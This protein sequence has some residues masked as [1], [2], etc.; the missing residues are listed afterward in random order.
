MFNAT[1]LDAWLAHI[2]ALHAKQID[3]GL[4]RMSLM[5]E[6]MAIAFPNQTVI[7]VGGTNGKGSTCSM[8]ESIYRAAGYRT[9]MHTSPHLIRM[10]ERC[11]VDGREVSDETLIAAF[12][13]VEAARGDMTL[14][15][16]EY[17]ALAILRI[18]VEERVDVVILEVGLGGRLD[19]I[20]TVDSNAAVV[21][22][23]GIDHVAFLGDTRE[24]IGFEKAHIFRGGCPAVCSEPDVP[25]TVL[26]KIDELGAKGL[27]ANRDFKVTVNADTTFDFEMGDLSW[28]RIP[29]PALKGVNQY[30]NVGG[31][32]AIVSSLQ[33]RLPV[34]REKV[35]EGLAAVRLTARFE[36]ITEKPVATVIDVGH[37]PQAALVLRE[38]VARTKKPAEKTLAV[39]GMLADK[40]MKSVMGILKDTFDE[41]FVASLTGPRAAMKDELA[42]AMVAAGVNRE[43]ITTYDDVAGAIAAARA[44]AEAILSPNA[45]SP[46]TDGNETVRIVVFGSFVTVTAALDVFREEGIQR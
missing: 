21:T 39:V 45:S 42:A 32:L 30:Q 13:E 25:A 9:G 28:K 43:K 16:F 6:K 4:D 38:N 44:R 24:K 20:N 40:D 14:S 19:A 26:A 18:F 22:T 34:T 11:V 15:F 1:T 2:E 23:V 37:N 27:V 36:L 12:R 3:L 8:L 31:V 7:T 17:T 10:N 46:K 29:E 41:W 5:V 33:E 35:E